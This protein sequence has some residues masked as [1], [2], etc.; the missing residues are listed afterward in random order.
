MTTLAAERPT[1]ANAAPP[2]LMAGDRLSRAEFEC[3]WELHP[4]IKRA[5]LIDGEVYLDTSVGADHGSAHATVAG[6][7]G[8]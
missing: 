5:E 1:A 4:E 7:V 3:R 8:I 6:W 2:P